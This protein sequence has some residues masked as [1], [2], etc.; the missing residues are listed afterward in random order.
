MAVCTEK[1]KESHILSLQHL[2]SSSDGVRE[3]VAQ[4]FSADIYIYHA[5]YSPKARCAKTEETPSIILWYHYSRMMSS[6]IVK[7]IV[8]SIVM[9]LKKLLF[10]NS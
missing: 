5:S 7:S 1:E 3:Y 6:L 4:V 10:I 9:M 2:M 8:K